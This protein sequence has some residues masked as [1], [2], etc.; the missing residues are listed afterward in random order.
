MRE[1]LDRAA[2]PLR[3]CAK[4]AGGPLFVEFTTAAQLAH[5]AAVSADV[6][7]SDVLGCVADSTREIRF[8]PTAPVFF[9]EVYSP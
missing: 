9:T 4:I 2:E 7:A 1:A 3:R 6:D 5:F 8:Q